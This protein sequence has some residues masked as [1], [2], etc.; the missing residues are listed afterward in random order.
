MAHRRLAE[1]DGFPGRAEVARLLDGFKDDE[2]VQIDAFAEGLDVRFHGARYTSKGLDMKNMNRLYSIN[3]FE[4]Y[5]AC[6]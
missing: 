4:T 3:S 6:P 5:H 1:A 2:Q